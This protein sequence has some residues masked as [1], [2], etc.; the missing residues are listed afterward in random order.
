M[1]REIEL[2]T[3][4]KDRLSNDERVALLVVA[5]STGSSPGRAGYKMAVGQSGDLIGSIGGGVMEVNL[6]EQARAILSEEPATA[7]PF[8]TALIEQEHRKNSDHPSG[9]ICSGRQA[10]LLRILDGTDLP[11]VTAAFDALATSTDAWITLSQNSFAVGQAEA[12]TLNISFHRVSN[13]EFTY[14]EKLGAKNDLIIIGGGHCALALSD[15]MSRM[16]FTIRIFDDRPKLNTLEK[17]EF[18]DE[19][20][21]IDSYAQ[22]AEHIAGGGDTYVVVMT[23]GYR[24]DEIVVR[25]LLSREFKYFGVLGSRAKMATLLRE[26]KDE[27]FPQEELDAIRTPIGIPINSHTPEEIAVSIAAEIISVK[28]A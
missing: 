27:G 19:I 15:L 17:N 4:I 14:T 20:T 24:T 28:N 7:N 5:E 11:H 9:M 12:C 10:I 18:A 8:R 6:V 2:W 25:A 16:D 13:S 22:L 3:F 1:P 23:L 21:I 26:L